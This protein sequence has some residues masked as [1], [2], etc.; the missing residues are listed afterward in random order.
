MKKSYM[1]KNST[2]SPAPQKRDVQESADSISD[3][4][5]RKSSLTNSGKL[6]LRGLLVR[7][8]IDDITLTN[9]GFQP[10]NGC[11]K[12]KNCGSTTNSEN[13]ARAVSH[14]KS[15]VDSINDRINMAFHKVSPV[16][17]KG[18][19]MPGEL[20]PSIPPEYYHTVY[21]SDIDNLNMSSE[22][23]GQ[24]RNLMKSI[25]LFNEKY[26]Y[27]TRKHQSFERMVEEYK[28]YKLS[29]RSEDALNEINQ[30]DITEEIKNLQVHNVFKNFNVAKDNFENILKDLKNTLTGER[31]KEKVNTVRVLFLLIRT[32]SKCSSLLKLILMSDSK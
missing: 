24:F 13:I 22:L 5:N 14:V 3:P 2:P 11:S 12:C 15:Y 30:N 27:I 10:N 16:N 1:R 20:D 8:S 32:R 18:S 7:N 6:K 29:N 9:E 19:Y 31:E 17:L 23:T 21:Y 25:R 28:G 26:D 4:N